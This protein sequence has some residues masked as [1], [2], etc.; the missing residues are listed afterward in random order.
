MSD[1]ANV[2]QWLG[3]RD[4]RTVRLESISIDGVITGKYVAR[5]KFLSGVRSGGYGFCDVVFGQD[6]FN[7]AQLGFDA[8]TWRAQMSDIN[9]VPDLATLVVDPVV[10]GLASVICNVT[11]Q[12][13][14]PLPTCSRSALAAQVAALADLGYETKAAIEIEA[15]IF[16][17]DIDEARAAGFTGL[18]PVGGGA[19]AL[20]VIGRPRL[21][22]EYMDS[23]TR[24]LDAMGVRWE[25]W[26]DESAAGQVEFNL[27]PADAL[28]AV[29]AYLR[30]KLAMRH[31]AYEMGLSVTFMA[32]WSADYFGQGSHINLSLYRDGR[33]AFAN[34]DVASEPTD[35]MRW[36][37][38]GALATMAAAASFAY[39]TMNSY[40]RIAE[41][42]GPPTTASWGVD[43]KSTAIR[44]ICRDA[45]QS[46][47]EY[48][49]PSSDAN[50]YLA[51]AA[52]LAGGRHGIEAR[53]DPPAPLDVM[54]WALPDG[55]APRLPD[56]MHEAIEALAADKVLTD[57]LGADL[58]AYWLGTRRWEWLQF[59]TTG[60]DPG[61]E[62]S[63]WELRRYFE[64]V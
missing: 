34:P 56:N 27:P 45:K 48:R 12:A 43:N 1:L 54:A 9:L 62:V 46:R 7:D 35:E 55:V 18:R 30:V 8:G 16:E 52:L 59:H 38:G 21:F 58:V 28:T 5:D 25:G 33:N 39:P 26:C 31:V 20:Y 42:T 2:E 57:L 24:R 37:I 22:N 3:E 6:L 60:G 14:V 17:N 19:G 64:L 32:R 61:P 47:V 29:D 11:D 53:T 51:F 63:A 13:G 44:A 4:V 10:P 23:V 41:L 40:R 36:F 50:P 49:V 15:T